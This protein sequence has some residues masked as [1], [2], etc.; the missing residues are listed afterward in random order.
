MAEGVT[1]LAAWLRRRRRR[2]ASKVE[3]RQLATS[4]A[5]TADGAAR[6]LEGQALPAAEAPPRPLAAAVDR[7]L[8]E[9]PRL[10]PPVGR[11]ALAE[12]R[13]E[14][15][16]R[17]SERAL[18]RVCH[19]G[20]VRLFVPRRAGWFERAIERLWRRLA[21][22]DSDRAVHVEI[23]AAAGAAPQVLIDGTSIETEERRG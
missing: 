17:A 6:D 20:A 15:V 21:A 7:F 22:P 12:V 14:F 16:A 9:R 3:L 11:P 2:R 1:S 8:G 13:L 18:S 10:V 23:R 19:G 5:R 4:L